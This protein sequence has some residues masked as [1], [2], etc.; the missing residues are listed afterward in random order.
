MEVK[1]VVLEE[2]IWEMIQNVMIN[3]EKLKECMESLH[4][5]KENIQV[6]L[7]RRL[8]SIDKKVSF[9]QAKKQRLIDLYAAGDLEKDVYVQK[10]VTYDTEISSLDAKRI[11]IASQIPVLHR[12]EE[13]DTSIQ[14][15]CQM[16]RIRLQKCKDAE[17]KRKFMLDFIEK[18]IYA[19]ENVAICGSVPLYDESSRDRSRDKIEFKIPGKI[20]ISDRRAKYIPYGEGGKPSSLPEYNLA[21]N[22]ASN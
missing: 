17:T 12:L 6:R 7:R 16:V 9:V 2:R 20:L 3:P 4:G 8:K 14:Q 15:Y 19:N 13:V 21:Q 18:I 22:I 5:K 11:E 1:T 10:N